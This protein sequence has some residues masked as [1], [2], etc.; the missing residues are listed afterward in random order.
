[1]SNGKDKHRD[2]SP[3]EHWYWGETPYKRV[4]KQHKKEANRRKRHLDKQIDKT[5]KSDL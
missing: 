3:W 4:K 1:M 2:L 5:T